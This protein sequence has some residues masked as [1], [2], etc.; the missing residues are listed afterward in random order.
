[1]RALRRNEGRATPQA[2]FVLRIAPDPSG[3]TPRR[4]L[5]CEAMPAPHR[6]NGR[7]VGLARAI[8]EQCVLDPTLRSGVVVDDQQVVGEVE[9]APGL[10]GDVRDLSRWPGEIPAAAGQH[11]FAVPGDHV[12]VVD[13]GLHLA[14]RVEIGQERRSGRLLGA[15]GT[16]R[17]GLARQR[18]RGRGNRPSDDRLGAGEVMSRAH[19]EG[20]L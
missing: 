6:Q 3:A 10:Q 13:S 7:K 11:D 2:T 8:A 4:R 15:G 12:R 14:T 17:I 1:M 18:P 19:E 16:H 9:R 20:W 5:Y